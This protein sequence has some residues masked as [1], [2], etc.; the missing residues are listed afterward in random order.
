MIYQCTTILFWRA[1]KYFSELTLF[2]SKLSVMDCDGNLPDY[3]F[4]TSLIIGGWNIAC[5][6]AIKWLS[7]DLTHDKSALV[8]V[9]AWFPQATSHYLSLCWPS[10]V[11]P[12]AFGINKPQKLA[13]NLQLNFKFIFFRIIFCILMWTSLKFVLQCPIENWR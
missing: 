8:E 11:L 4:Q 13:N 6:I 5:E 3:N 7:R 2:F 9:M 1:I 12:L 10:S